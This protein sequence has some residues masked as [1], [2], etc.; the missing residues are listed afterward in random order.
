MI[1]Y[2]P[3]RLSQSTPVPLSIAGYRIEQCLGTDHQCGLY[4]VGCH[5]GHTLLLKAVPRNRASEAAQA[6]LK[7]EFEVHRQ[8][9]VEGLVKVIELVEDD[10]HLA[11][12]YEDAGGQPLDR[13]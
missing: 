2:S 8:L 4:R 10:G 6:R 5:G 9:E 1:A 11:L 3:L 13:L 7:H 12:V